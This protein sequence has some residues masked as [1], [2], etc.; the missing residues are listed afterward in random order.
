MVSEAPHQNES[1]PHCGKTSIANQLWR[2]LV[3]SIFESYGISGPSVI[4]KSDQVKFETWTRYR[5]LVQGMPYNS[6]YRN[7]D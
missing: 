1:A 2:D 3:C 6:K 7:G 4:V 5:A